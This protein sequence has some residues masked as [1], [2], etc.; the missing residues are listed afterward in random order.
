MGFGAWTAPA[1]VGWGFPN[2][3]CVV[4][5][6]EDEAISSGVLLSLVASCVVPVWGARLGAIDKRFG[7]L[8]A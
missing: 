2:S 6:S 1:V 7:E 4:V 8:C 5:G 3:A